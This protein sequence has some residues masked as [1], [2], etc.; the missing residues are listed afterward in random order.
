MNALRFSIAALIKPDSCFGLYTRPLSRVAYGYKI[1]III[2]FA[3]ILND[4]YFLIY[5]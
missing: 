4:T 2:M 3:L 5:M 1:Y